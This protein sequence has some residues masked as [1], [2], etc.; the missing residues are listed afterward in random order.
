MR[1]RRTRGRDQLA[2]DDLADQVL[3]QFQ[4]VIIGRAAL[5]LRHSSILHR[6]SAGARA[7]ALSPTSRAQTRARAGTG[8]GC[9]RSGA[10]RFSFR[11]RGQAGRCAASAAHRPFAAAAFAYAT[12]WQIAV[13]MLITAERVRSHRFSLFPGPRSAVADCGVTRPGVAAKS[14]RAALFDHTFARL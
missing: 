7:A 14:Q 6:K 13:T 1:R 3:R 12:N 11:R 2:L 8:A 9:W 5:R 10:R 4:E